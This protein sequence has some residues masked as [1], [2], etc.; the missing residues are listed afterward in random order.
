[1][2]K[3]ISMLIMLLIFLQL[4]TFAYAAGGTVNV[5][6]NPVEGGTYKAEGNLSSSEDGKTVTITAIPNEVYSFSNWSY[7]NTA[8]T[9]MTA[10]DNPHSFDVFETTVTANFVKKESVTV[11]VIVADGQGSYGAVSGSGTFFK[12]S[13]VS[14]KAVPNTGYE[15]DK[16]STGSNKAEDTIS[17]DSNKTISASFKPKSIT[18][19]VDTEGGG[20][21]TK[22]GSNFT[23]ETITYSDV[24][25]YVTLEAVPSIGNKFLGWYDLGGAFVSSSAKAPV[26][27]LQY[28]Y[29]K[30]KFVPQSSTEDPDPS[31][32]DPVDPSP[33]KPDPDPVP[34]DPVKPDPVPDPYHPYKEFRITYHPGAYGAEPA[35]QDIAVPGSGWLRGSTF[36]RPGYVQA[37]WSWDPYGKEFNAALYAPMPMLYENIT[38]YPYWEPIKGPLTLTVG[39]SG[40]GAIQVNG[41]YV[42]NGEG[43]TLRPGESLTFGFY[44]ASGNYVYSVLLAGRYREYPGYGFTVTYDMM[45]NRNQTLAVRFESVYTRPK[46][47][48]DSN[49][50]LWAALGICS[51]VCLGVLVVAKKKKK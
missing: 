46:T 13:N 50:G 35:V 18:L 45:Q 3:I 1:M 19:K 4:L 42:Y 16:W 29:L 8:G 9:S 39:Y 28:T 24:N 41:R 47:G 48:D 32:T 27:I 17:A 2:K 14:I 25:R 5:V 23:S 22:G 51:A 37:G 43:F 33:V 36:M 20:Y 21:V 6:V 40:S 15:F 11:T 31:K 26:D 44:P 12:G 38:V 34:P 30:A 10:T 49:I 7:K